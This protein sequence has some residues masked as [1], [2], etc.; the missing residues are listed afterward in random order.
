MGAKTG[1]DQARSPNLAGRILHGLLAQPLWVLLP[2]MAIIL[3]GFVAVR[4]MPVATM[5]EMEF[6]TIVVDAH[7][8]GASS[9][10]ISAT[11]TT[12]LER[13]FRNLPYLTS[14]TSESMLGEVELT[15]QFSPERSLEAASADVQNALATAA[16]DL[17]ADMPSP[18]QYHNANPTIASVVYVSFSSKVMSPEQ[19][20][21]VVEKIARPMLRGVPGVGDVVVYGARRRSLEITPDLRRLSANH[22]TLED[23]R[24][25]VTSNSL[26]RPKGA[27]ETS[28]RRTII[29]TDD[30]LRRPAEFADIAVSRRANSIVRLADVAVVSEGAEL[31]N[32]LGQVNG[33]PAVIVGVRRALGANTLA[34]VDGVRSL[35]PSLRRALPPTV[36]FRL[37]ADRSLSVQGSVRDVERT[38]CLTVLLVSLTVFAFLRRVRS[39]MIAATVIPVSILGTVATIWLFGFS[40]NNISLIALTVCVGLVVDDA[41]VVIERTAVRIDQGLRPREAAALALND[42]GFTILTVTVS[43]IAAFI[44][45]LFMA[46][47]TGRLFREFSITLAVAVAISGVASVTLTQLLCRLGMKPE[48]QPARNDGEPSH[49]WYAASLR[50]AISRSTWVLCAFGAASI[51]SALIYVQIDKGFFPSEDTRQI[52]GGLNTPADAS[53]LAMHTRMR[54]ATAILLND[55]AVAH[56]V[57]TATDTTVYFL[58]DLRP[59]PETGSSTDYLN[60]VRTAASKLPELGMYL[61]VRPELVIGNVT[62]RSQYEY[63]VS[64]RDLDELKQ[65]V[66]RLVERL[67]TV[68][69]LGNIAVDG[70]DT[71]RE[72]N[73]QIDRT[74]ASNAG[75]SIRQID[76]TLYDAFGSRRIAQVFSDADQVPV[77]LRLSPGDSADEDT[78]SKLQVAGSDGALVALN[79]LLDPHTREGMLTIRHEGLLPSA[80]LTFDVE[81]GTPLDAAFDAILAAQASLE[82]PAGL[83][84]SF[85]GSAGEFRSTL[86]DEPALIGL[87]VL[88]IWLVLGLLYRSFLHP[89]TILSTV[90]PAGLGALL[91]LKI[92]GRPL[93]MMAFV[94]IVVLIGVVKKNAILVVDQALIE[95]DKPGH[96]SLQEATI[97][98]AAGRL[99]PILITTCAAAAGAIP[100]A[101]DTGVGSELRRPLGVAI[102]GGLVL[103]QLITLYSVPVLHV[104]FATLQQRVR[105]A[106]LKAVVWGRISRSFGTTQSVK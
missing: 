98:A 59:E 21:A 23:I 93:D 65:W 35:S 61:Q 46:G 14:V 19:V 37:L 29:A 66:P 36:G 87:A 76:D 57:A 104:T 26:N 1:A 58:I 84:T 51:T 34:T 39:A 47:L 28:T 20:T 15:L 99:R 56:V 27:F 78:L 24:E 88:C 9:E 50:W 12:P 81:G 42:V 41:I 18:P 103:S 106:N 10:T 86:K 89:L 77:M 85:V 45:L 7:F 105:T 97:A 71:I 25:A 64:A 40:L 95:R 54:E 2:T 11:L 30:Q 102:L 53:P 5:P 80:T 16:P 8:P 100:L 52:I 38:L 91:T 49:R 31:P 43:L 68:P 17:P 82:R 67:R 94:G 60:R 83:T 72:R 63:R 92:L 73:F 55:P 6:P 3:L 79:T 70:L 74:R 69:G 62:G 75:V 32:E 44:P 13:A 101:F 22:L 96:R 48:T 33:E 90:L 4:R